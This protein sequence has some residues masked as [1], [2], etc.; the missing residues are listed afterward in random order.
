MKI[1]NFSLLNRNLTP[2]KIAYYSLIFCLL[3]SCN[4]NKP[5]TAGEQLA[6]QNLKEMVSAKNFEI[7]AHTAKPMMNNALTQ[8]LN[9]NLLPPGNTPSH[10]NIIGTS[11]SLK[12]KGDSIQ[13]NLPFYGEQFSGVNP[14]SMPRGISFND[15]PENYKVTENVS[16]RSIEIS[17]KIKDNERTNE[18]YDITVTLFSGKGSTINI[19]PTTR[20]Y[21]QFIGTARVLSTEGLA[22]K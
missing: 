6:F 20:S 16:K 13:A 12:I 3:L 15:I 10:I 7:V 18:R 5:I 9:A 11:N 19:W 2:M 22:E 17:F 4:I 8:V 1:N 14:G 21:I